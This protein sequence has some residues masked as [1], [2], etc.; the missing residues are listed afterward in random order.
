[1]A[2]QAFEKRG[3]KI[4]TGCRVKNVQGAD[5]KNNKP[6]RARSTVGP[7]PVEANAI[8]VATNTPAPINDWMGIYLEA[9][10]LSHVS[11]IG[12]TSAARRR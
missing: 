11:C 4:Y 12:R 9:G 1:M 6:A 3:G 7:S 10:L 2:S 5:P 8:I